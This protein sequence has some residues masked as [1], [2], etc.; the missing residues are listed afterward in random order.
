MEIIFLKTELINN[1]H[2]NRKISDYFTNYTRNKQLLRSKPS[3][4]I[5][6]RPYKN[7][8][9]LLEEFRIILKLKIIRGLFN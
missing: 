3:A 1:F 5:I 7:Y 4:R 9:N 6:R 2:V 8:K